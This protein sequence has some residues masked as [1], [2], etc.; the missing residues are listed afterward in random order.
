MVRDVGTVVVLPLRRR[1]LF[2]G[3]A[4]PTSFGISLSWSN[5]QKDT[6]VFLMM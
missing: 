5:K 4:C 1:V 6:K 2:S 3:G